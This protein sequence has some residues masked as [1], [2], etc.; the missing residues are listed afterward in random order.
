[1]FNFSK[2]SHRKPVQIHQWR[3]YQ[4][5]LNKKEAAHQLYRRLPAYAALACVMVFLIYGISVFIGKIRSEPAT[6]AYSVAVPDAIEK[7]D[8]ATLQKMWILRR[9]L[10]PMGTVDA[11]EF[12]LGKLKDTKCNDDFFNGMNQ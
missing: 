2:R 5:D 1:M 4:S 6:K 12:L 8:K 10:N 7:F 11:M 3:H 9:I